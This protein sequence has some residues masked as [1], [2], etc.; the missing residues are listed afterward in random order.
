MVAAEWEIREATARESAHV[1]K[2]IFRAGLSDHSLSPQEGAVTVASLDDLH[3]TSEQSANVELEPSLESLGDPYPTLRGLWDRVASDGALTVSYGTDGDFHLTSLEVKNLLRLAGF[4]AVSQYAAAGARAI[5]AR[6]LPRSARALSCSVVVPCRNEVDNVASLV[7]RVP[8]LGTETEIVFVDGSSN[9]G[10]PERIEELVAEYPRKNIRL[11]RQAGNTGKA[12]ATFQG[13]GAAE[14]DVVMILDADM[15]VRPEDLPRFYD[16]LAEGVAQFANGT[17]MVYPMASGAMPG[18]NNVGNRIFSHYLSWLIGTHISDTLCGTKAMLRQD[19]PELLRL[20]PSF[21]Y[22]DPWGD[23]DLLLGAAC[24]GLSIIDVPVIYVAR[25]AGESKM[26]PWAH[27]SELAKTCLI[28]VRELKLR[29][30]RRITVS[31]TS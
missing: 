15:T 16:A 26:Q 14:G 22:H 8:A 6:R 1:V 31:S 3:H 23:F 29:Q 24:L 2:L 19:T 28:G 17:R 7:Q 9:D 21:G 10:T 25:E 20:R 11:I 4:Q 13:F 12:G 27:G 30:H 5:V 18:L